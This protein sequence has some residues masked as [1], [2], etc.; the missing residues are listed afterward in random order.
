MKKILTLAACL[1]ALSLTAPAK[2]TPKIGLTLSGGGAKGA[3]HIGV[4]K[5]MEE[6]G[7]PIDCIAG[8]SMGSIIGAM[9]SLGYT[10]DEMEEIIRAI[11]WNE[12]IS[13]YIDRSSMSFETKKK[14]SFLWTEIPFNSAKNIKIRNS[15]PGGFV[16]GNNI[17]NLFNSLCV[18]YNDEMNF[19]KLPIP[20]AC[21]ATDIVTG[22]QV[23]FHRG[24]LP[25]C[26]RASMAIPGVF[27]PVRIGDK[28]LIDGGMLDNF[29][30]DVCKEMGADIVIGVSVSNKYKPADEV[31]TLPQLAEMLTVLVTQNKAGENRELCRIY[32]HPDVEGYSSLSFDDE[33]IETLIERGY[34]EASKHRAE[35]IE[36]RRMLDE[37]GCPK[38][39]RYR[40][41]KA[42]NLTPFSEEKIMLS[43][44]VMNGLSA[45]DFQWLLHESGLDKA[46]EVT[47]KDIQ[48]LVSICYG[49]GAFKS[50]TYK[51]EGTLVDGK[52]MYALVM[53][54]TPAEPHNVGISAHFD[55]QTAASLYYRLGL[56]ENRISGDK[57]VLEGSVGSNN[58]IKLTGTVDKRNFFAGNISLH[59]NRMC[60]TVA[61]GGHRNT[62]ITFTDYALEAYCSH[63]HSRNFMWEIG[64]KLDGFKTHDLIRSSV[65]D[66]ST[67]TAEM[68]NGQ[69]L[70]LFSRSSWDNLDDAWFAT[71]GIRAKL[72]MDTRW[73]A[74]SNKAIWGSA[75][76]GIEYYCPVRDDLTFIPQFYG[77]AII[78]D[79][80]KISRRYCNFIGGPVPSQII[81]QQI[82]FIGLNRIE[83]VSNVTGIFRTDLRWNPAGLWHFSLLSN[84]CHCFDSEIDILGVGLRLSYNGMLGPVSAEVHWS[85]LTRGAGF[86]FNFGYYF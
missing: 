22:E 64:L 73:N 1:F 30:V 72:D 75:K 39:T 77:R 68:L 27:A 11:E 35:F 33:S 34:R 21:V 43:N 85:T 31:N 81:D 17:L 60:S 20:F 61:E 45:N 36:L 78:G 53:D 67:I 23:D 5:V 32:I 71:R 13:D 86:Y 41:P 47:G 59:A 42:K 63:N 70:G 24:V 57:L 25:Q 4:L 80:S 40:A 54:F 65:G 76:F 9:Y 55:S 46:S 69:A 28:V 66:E 2:N 18:G 84:W 50:I 38:H 56:G 6:V 26:L 79:D 7:I 8:T 62:Y 48:R 3:A 14:D 37:L 15:L 44:L 16:N 19:N 51:L 58:K 82:P 52:E 10:P 74:F 49:T 83:T 12:Y 29:P